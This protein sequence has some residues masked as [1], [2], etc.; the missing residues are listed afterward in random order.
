MA[1][2]R[3]DRPADE[4][5]RWKEKDPVLRFEREL[6]NRGLID[7]D[8]IRLIH[9]TVSHEIEQ[10]HDVAASLPDPPVDEGTKDVYASWDS[11]AVYVV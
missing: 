7:D 8:E 9:E 3:E 1:V 6:K 5:E 10:A 2:L 11:G 4:I